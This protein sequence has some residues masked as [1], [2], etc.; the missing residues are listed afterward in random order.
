MARRPRNAAGGLDGRRNAAEEVDQHVPSGGARNRS[1]PPRDETSLRSASRDWLTLPAAPRPG[2]PP[3]WPLSRPIA[4]ETE[5]WTLLWTK[6][7]AILWAQHSQE[8]EVALHVRSLVVAEKRTATTSA[9][10]LIR[11]QMDSLLLTLPALR[12]AGIRIG[13]HAERAAAPSPGELEAGEAPATRPARSD[14]VDI[15]D[16]LPGGHGAE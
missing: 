7:Q 3:A 12:A 10:T 11:Q 1:G 16:R 14:V 6:P 15:R 4:R 5:L 2:P 8:L 9:R 13:T